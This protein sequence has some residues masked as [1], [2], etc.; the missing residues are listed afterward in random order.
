MKELKTKDGVVNFTM[1]DTYDGEW[2]DDKPNG[3]GT[4]KSNYYKDRISASDFMTQEISGNYTNGLEDG[5]MTLV[6]TTKGG[7][8][9][10]F[11]YKAKDGIAEQ[12]TSESSGV[13]GQFIIAQTDDKSESLTS[14]GSVRGVE[15]FTEEGT[16]HEKV[17]P[18]ATS[19]Q[20]L[21]DPQELQSFDDIGGE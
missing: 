11:K 3:A 21:G 15:G 6:G 1:L 10:T 5:D 2:S 14:D 9:R 7:Q 17:S 12:S 8:K 18:S 13:K 4:A 16:T 20:E 19:A